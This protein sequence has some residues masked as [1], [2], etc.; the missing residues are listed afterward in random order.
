MRQGKKKVY[1]AVMVLGGAALLVD[2]V[3]LSSSVDPDVAEATGVAPAD[4]KPASPEAASPTPQTAP[5]PELNFPRQIP[6]YD[7]GA[8]LRDWFEPPKLPDAEE[9]QEGTPDNGGPLALRA[10]LPVVSAKESFVASH[11]LDGIVINDRW[12]IAIVD[13]VWLR[14]GQAM[15][16]CTLSEV[17][18]R[19]AVFACEDGD[20]QLTLFQDMLARPP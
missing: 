18:G 4:D 6:A 19:T 12:Q 1:L 5:I 17:S 20:A 11:R 16:D 9:P 2:R 7:V 14:V 8:H 15:D 3:F 13:G 10:A